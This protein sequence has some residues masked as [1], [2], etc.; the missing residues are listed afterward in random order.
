MKRVDKALRLLAA[1]I[2]CVFFASAAHVLLRFVRCIRSASSIASMESYD[3]VQVFLFGSSGNSVSGSV[4]IMNADGAVLAQLERSW[5][6]AGFSI[7]FVTVSLG[8]RSFSFP[9]RVYANRLMP[10][11]SR[12]GVVLAKYYMRGRE[13]LL[14]ASSLHPL[15]E[16]ELRAR[17]YIADFALSPVAHIFA[18]FI[19]V[20]TVDLSFC[21]PG[22]TYA[23]K[24]EANGNLFL[25]PV[26]D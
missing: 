17:Y 18:S 22:R 3:A 7:D 21:V 1:C 5:N 25:Y 16:Q 6:S 20:Q 24:A 15:T 26:T 11:R 4:S 2:L 23:I 12:S 14:F 19:K 9:E 8:A 10:V 13:C